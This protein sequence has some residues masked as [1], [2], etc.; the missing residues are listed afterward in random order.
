ME[1]N[2][3]EVDRKSKVLGPGLRYIIWVQGCLKRCP[4]C[5]NTDFQ[6]LEPKEIMT[7]E[8]LIEDI[9]EYKDKNNLEGITLLGG[10]PLLQATQLSLI[11]RAAKENGLSVLC[12]TGYKYE[13]IKDMPNIAKLLEYTDVL[14]DGE[15]II[16]KKI[17]T[18]Y[19]GSSNQNVIFLTDRYNEKDFDVTNSYEIVITDSKLRIKG[20]Y[21]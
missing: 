2:I 13:E 17:W 15:F 21:K 10:E 11:A 4:E 3:A 14:I 20:F 12:Y 7:T 18:N 5:Y 16:D 19:K 8:E 6:P 9:L 1:L